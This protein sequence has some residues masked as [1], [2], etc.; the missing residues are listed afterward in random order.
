MNDAYIHTVRLLLDV[1][2]AVFDTPL[3]A[4]KG[5]TALNLFVQD[6]PRLSVD[7]DVVFVRHDLVREDALQAI[8]LELAAAQKRVAALGHQVELRRNRDGAEAKMFVRSADAEVKVEVNFVFRGTVMA[9]TRR[10]LTL[11]AQQMFAADIQVP[12]LADAE[13]YGSKLVAALDRQHPRD[14]FDVQLMLDTHGWEEALLDCFVVYLAGHN[15][16]PHEVLFPNEKPLKAVFEAEFEGMTTEPVQLG[17]LL[18][19]RRRM[20]EELPR[21]LLPRHCDFLLSM[22]RTE[23]DWALLPHAHLERLPALQWKLENL[24]RLKKNAA[25]FRLQHDELAARLAQARG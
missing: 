10:S 2:P 6:M 14:L 23:P 1:A 12:V 4:M 18:A 22:V 3:F 15:R 5:G 21:A 16:P 9:P 20:F 25:K 19:T 7:I 24:N 8:G 11:A 13:L 17:A